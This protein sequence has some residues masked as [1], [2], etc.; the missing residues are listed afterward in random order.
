MHKNNKHQND[1]DFEKLNQVVPALKEFVFTNKYGSKTIDFANPKAI[2]LFNKSLL[3]TYYSINYW[4]FPDNHL[5]PPIPGRVDYI[6]HLAELI[7]PYKLNSVKVLDIGTGA[8]GIYPLLGNSV[9][10]WN[11][12]G[13]D[14]DVEA[15]KNAQTIINKN[16]LEEFIELRLQSN[17]AQILNGIINTNENFTFCMCNPPFYKNEQEALEATKRKL[18]GLK[19]EHLNPIRNFSG[20][21]NELWYPVGEK[22]FLHNYLYESSLYKTNCFW[23]TSLVSNKDLVQSMQKSL[24]KL[25]STQV[26]IINMSQGNKI[27]RIVAWT[28]LSNEQQKEW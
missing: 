4:E 26:K 1:Y 15:L 13:T 23:Y 22:A 11:F 14:V 19:K 2:K 5:C 12:I 18:R 10:N 8:T 16:N 3:I 21:A 9:Y 17:K 24:K 27:S 20:S 28:F 7:E 6:H 25:G